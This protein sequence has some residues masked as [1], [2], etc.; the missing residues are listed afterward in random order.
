[1]KEGRIKENKPRRRKKKKKKTTATTENEIQTNA[2][3]TRKH[4]MDPRF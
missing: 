1:M 4:W 3:K 2:E